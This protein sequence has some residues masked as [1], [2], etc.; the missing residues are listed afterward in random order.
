MSVLKLSHYYGLCS[1]CE[2]SS[3]NP[4]PKL[5]FMTKLCSGATVSF[6]N[7]VLLYNCQHKIF[8]INKYRCI[9][10]CLL[11]ALLHVLVQLHHY[12]SFSNI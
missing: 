11:C 6:K 12:V 1:G 4:K 8:I 7:I 9:N 2:I 3:Q 10:I 5:S